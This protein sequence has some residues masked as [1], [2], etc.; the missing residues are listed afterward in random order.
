MTIKEWK[1]IFYATCNPK[2][3]GVA[4]LISNKVDFKTKEIVT[5]DKE[6]HY[7]MRIGSI[8]QEDTTII[9]IHAP[10]NKVPKYIK[11]EMTELRTEIDNS[12]IIVADFNTSISII[13]RKTIQKLNK[14]RRFEQYY[15]PNRSIPKERKCPMEHFPEQIIS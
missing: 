6:R 3:S 15:K 14:D 12:T 11:Q 8:D 2:R 5:K 7:I 4:L 1:T 9:N 10:K 13:E